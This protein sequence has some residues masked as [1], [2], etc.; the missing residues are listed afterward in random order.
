MVAVELPLERGGKA[1]FFVGNNDFV[2]SQPAKSADHHMCFLTDSNHNNG[3]WAINLSYTDTVQL[4]RE[5][6]VHC[7]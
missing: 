7:K 1:T 6:L 4:I 3:G 5:A 2:I